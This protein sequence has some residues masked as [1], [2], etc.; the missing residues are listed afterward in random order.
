MKILLVAS[1]C[2]PLVKVGG[3]ADVVGS[4]PIALSNLGIDVR[5]VIPYYKPLLD[6]AKLDAIDNFT[7]DYG[8][9]N[10]DV[11]IHKTTLSNS[12]VTVYLL[13]N[14]QFLT[15]GGVYFSPQHMS[16][17]NEE[18]DR[19]AF[20]SKAVS[21]YFSYENKIFKPELIHCN[22]WHTGLIPQ[23]LQ[24]MHNYNSSQIPKTIFTIHNLAYQGFTGIDMATKLGLD[25]KTDQTLKWDATDDNLDMVLQGIIGSVYITTVSEKYAEEIQTPEYGEGLHEIL[26]ARKD[27]L[28]GILNGISYEVFDPLKDTNL[29]ANY[30]KQDFAIGKAKNKKALQKEL[31]LEVKPDVP[32]IGIIS[33]LASQKG[34]NLVSDALKDICSNNCQVVLLGTGDPQ[35]EASFK[36]YN[37]DESLKGKYVGLIQFSEQ[38]ARRIYASSDM[39]LVPSKYEPCGLTQMIAMRYGS[40]PIVRAT[41]GLYDTVLDGRTG[42]TFTDFSTRAMLSPIIRA[43]E[44]YQ[45]KAKWNKMASECMTQDFSW[46]QSAKKYVALYQKT[47]SL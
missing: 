8:D 13:K 17:P 6:A 28:K 30:S 35:L 27:R 31:G 37:N 12:N 44:F 34:L 23:I 20:F 3:I 22:D 2:A 21:R 46:T 9:K 29:Y 11:S 16:S 10:Y 45:D 40:V 7:V 19:F 4:L 38:I 18:I 1:E 36:E 41:G 42:F 25:V 26:E 5:V 39:F 47:L 15:N 43:I 24:S 32:L 33:R 14:D